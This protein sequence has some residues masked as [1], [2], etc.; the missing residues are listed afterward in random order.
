MP[1]QLER[2]D[3]EIFLGLVGAVGT[4]LGS[5]GHH[6]KDELHRVGYSADIIRLSDLMLET[7]RY[8]ELR[9]LIGGY[10]DERINQ[11]MD[12][13]DD[14]RAAAMRGDA[15]ALLAISKV[16]AQREA[17]PDSDGEPSNRHAYIFHSLKHPTEVDTLRKVYGQALFIISVYSPRHTRL[18]AL[19]DR[20]SRSRQ[21]YAADLYS[22][23]AEALIEKD[24]QE[25]GKP[26]G[27]NVRETFPLGD[28]F[29]DCTEL[30]RAKDQITRFIEVLFSSPY[31]TPTMDEYGMFHAKAAALRSADLSRQVGAVI[32]TDHGE[33]IAAGCNEVPKAGGGA[34]WEGDVHDQDKDYR[35]FRIGHDST[36]RMKQEIMRKFLANFR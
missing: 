36:A 21:Q 13:G 9:S 12:A 7:D 4:D 15:V 11:L 3:P 33:I 35:D 32:M 10:E 19:S 24:E 16:R 5:I 1:S 31:M 29:I 30:K 18:S 22:D 23:T 8:A 28:V 27:Q 14:F 26:F 34:V 2:S 25:A 6:L 17:L 20:I